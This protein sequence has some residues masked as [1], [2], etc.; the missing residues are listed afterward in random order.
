MITAGAERVCVCLPKLPHFQRY[1][2]LFESLR[3]IEIHTRNPNEIQMRFIANCSSAG[4]MQIDLMMIQ[5]IS[6]SNES[7]IRPLEGTG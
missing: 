7:L 1:A 2:C 4:N 6:Q 5:W 3:L